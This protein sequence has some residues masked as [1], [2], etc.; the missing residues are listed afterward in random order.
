MAEAT[1]TQ[2]RSKQTTKRDRRMRSATERQSD[3]VPSPFFG[4][5]QIATN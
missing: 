5:S 2:M 3:I 1:S 4:V